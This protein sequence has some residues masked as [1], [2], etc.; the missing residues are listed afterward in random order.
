MASHCKHYSE[1]GTALFC[2]TPQGRK[3]INGC[4]IGKI[5]L[6]KRKIALVNEVASVDGGFRRL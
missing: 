3:I 6:E 1:K 4:V 2:L 5:I